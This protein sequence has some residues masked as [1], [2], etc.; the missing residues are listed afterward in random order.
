MRVNNCLFHLTPNTKN[1]SGLVFFLLI[2]SSCITPLYAHNLWIIGDANKNGDGTVHLYFAHNVGPSDGNYIEPIAKRGKTWLQTINAEPNQIKLNDEVTE[3]GLKYLKGDIGEIKP[4]F[5]LDH[6]SLYG[7]YH[8]RLDFFYGRYIQVN[9]AEELSGLAESPHMPFQIVPVGIENG[10]LL[11]VMFFSNPYPRSEV[12][13]LSSDGT[14]KQFKTNQK[15]EVLIP[16]NKIGTYHLCAY[17]FEHDAAGAFEY[18][19]FKG[20]MYGSTLT[21]NFSKDSKK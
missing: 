9:K 17:A 2:I 3:N 21:I 19:A 18:E 20:I 16:I 7:I 6:S 5:S 8:G 10:L 4:P 11:R 13:L 15:G 14:E 1:I 12:T